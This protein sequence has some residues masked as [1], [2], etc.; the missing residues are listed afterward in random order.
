MRVTTPTGTAV[1]VAEVNDTMMDGH[2][3]L[4]N[5]MGL[6]Y[7]PA[8]GE[9]ELTG[10]APNELTSTTWRDPIVGTPWH[11]HVPAHLEAV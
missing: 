6:A 7:A 4:P 9:P 2:I 10:V 8:G 1:A 11:K 3:S 5:G